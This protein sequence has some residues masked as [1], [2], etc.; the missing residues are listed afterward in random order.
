MIK[1]ILSL[2]EQLEDLLLNPAKITEASSPKSILS[3]L[4]RLSPDLSREKLVPYDNFIDIGEIRL[5][6]YLELLELDGFVDVIGKECF[7]SNHDLLCSLAG[8]FA[9]GHIYYLLSQTPKRLRNMFFRLLDRLSSSRRMAA[10]L[11]RQHNDDEVLANTCG[12]LL[13]IF[14]RFLQGLDVGN[15]GIILENYQTTLLSPLIAFLD[16]HFLENALPSDDLLISG[17]LRFLIFLTESRITI[18]IFIDADLPQRCLV[19]LVLPFL[20]RTYY[21]LIMHL[22]YNVA[23]HDDGVRVL[24]EYH[25]QA[26]LERFTRNI[27]TR[28]ID[29]TLDADTC[30]AVNRRINMIILLLVNYSEL[31][32][33]YF[34]TFI[35]SILIPRAVQISQSLRSASHEFD[36]PQLLLLLDK[37]CS[38][39]QL[40][41]RIF[42]QDHSPPFYATVLYLYTMYVETMGIEE[43]YLESH[44]RIILALVNILWSVSFHDRY[45]DEVR[46]ALDSVQKLEKLYLFELVENVPPTVYVP[47]HI[48]SFRRAMD[49][50]WE[51]LNP[52]IPSAL[53]YRSS[54]TPL[55]SV[56]ISYSHADIEFTQRLATRLSEVPQLSIHLDVNSCKYLWKETAQ[57]IEQSD[58][59]LLLLSEDYCRSKSCRQELIYAVDRLK[60]PILS[61][62]IEPKCDQQGWLISRTAGKDPILFDANDFTKSCNELL[63]RMNELLSLNVLAISEEATSLDIKQWFE[64]NHLPLEFCEF[65]QFQ[66]R[67]EL[68]LFGKAIRR[69]SWTTEFD[70]IKA[71]FEE[72]FP[73]QKL[74]PHQF[75]KFIDAVSRL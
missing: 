21:Q 38:C 59:V 64:K 58:V 61:L 19:W 36:L 62:L 8:S 28:K 52:S 50:I 9:S 18:P 63:S 17:I 1:Q 31:I 60:K 23:C 73:E 32:N 74:S 7:D 6:K 37:I 11:R 53:P 54:T 22:V 10:F 26:V 66:N 20:N 55:C 2:C 44:V 43:K 48:A 24:K 30:C 69:Y 72:K 51:N 70:R 15:V 29:F 49:G 65:Y 56:M 4:A 14:M 27:L 16:T 13:V 45:K 12:S 39:E 42:H 71:R 41:S 57:T 46:T 68:L 34:E 47:R 3:A 25:C 35:I 5:I 33:S 67:N 75:L 40:V